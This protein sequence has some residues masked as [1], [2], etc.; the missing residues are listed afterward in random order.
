M[1]LADIDSFS[2]LADR[3]AQRGLGERTLRKLASDDPDR[4]AQRRDLA[5]IGEATGL[6]YEFFTAD[7]W[8]LA[9]N[10]IIRPAAGGGVAVE[11]ATDEMANR[12]RP[13]L[14]AL[15]D[16]ALEQRASA[17][18][19]DLAERLRRVEEILVSHP[20][21]DHRRELLDALTEETTEALSAGA[22]TAPDG[23]ADDGRSAS[24]DDRRAAPRVLSEETPH[25]ERRRAR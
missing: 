1:E 11:M 9:S 5:A 17:R 16:E 15:L 12:F 22:E 21:S 2:K 10:R 6:P 3:I 14:Q 20:Q 23:Q 8:D 13:V 25:T 24:A 4:T 19:Q 18:E 7:F